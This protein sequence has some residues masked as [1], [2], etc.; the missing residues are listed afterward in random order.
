MAKKKRDRPR[1]HQH[2][3]QEYSGQSG[4][5]FWRITETLWDA[6]A[7]SISNMKLVFKP[8]LWEA[9]SAAELFSR[10]AILK[11]ILWDKLY[12]SGSPLAVWPTS[13]VVLCRQSGL[14]KLL[15]A[16]QRASA[17]AAGL[18][19][20]LSSPPSD[21]PSAWFWHKFWDFTCGISGLLR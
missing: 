7:I 3:V 4:F 9:P 17:F 20:C 21:H 14:L 8:W 2:W 11:K 15:L 5:T 6:K 1:R 16:L 19:Y 10:L 12:S 13:A 18:L